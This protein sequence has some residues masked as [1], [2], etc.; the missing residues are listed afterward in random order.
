MT[1]LV[2]QTRREKVTRTYNCIR[3]AW[4]SL[5]DLESTHE[6]SMA[7][8]YEHFANPRLGID[9]RSPASDSIHEQVDPDN[10]LHELGTILGKQEWKLAEPPLLEIDAVNPPARTRGRSGGF[11]AIARMTIHS[12][13]EKS[14]KI[15][16]SNGVSRS[17]SSSG[18]S[19]SGDSWKHAQSSLEADVKH[20]RACNLAGIPLSEFFELRARHIQQPAT[21][22]SPIGRYQD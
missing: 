5:Y 15:V 7:K 11:S 12:G 16:R 13:Y 9:L 1:E 6:S 17:M 18:G 4:I 21:E 20:W 10:L 14:K 19:D 8:I 2:D 22:L 3:D